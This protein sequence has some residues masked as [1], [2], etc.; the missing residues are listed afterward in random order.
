MNKRVRIWLMIAAALLLLGAMAFAG[1]M[2]ILGWDFSTITTIRYQSKLHNITEN[3]QNIS[4]ECDTANVIFLP[5][6]NQE[7]QVGCYEQKNATHTVT[8]NGDDLIIKIEDKRKWYEHIGIFIDRPIVALY[9]P[10]STYGALKINSDTGDVTI[11]KNFTFQSIDISKDTGDIT[12]LASA[13]DEVK[14]KTSTGDIS[15][16]SITAKSLDLTVSTGD[17]SVFDVKCQTLLS[18]GNTGDIS[19]QNVIAEGKFSIERSTGDV[20]FKKCDA[21]EIFVTTDT[22]DVTGS[23]Q[24]EKIFFAQSDTGRIDVPKTIHGGRCEIISDTGNIKINIE[25]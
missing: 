16:K 25:S 22:G 15:L 19:L 4:I 20:K 3:F 8:V 23:L 2:T 11:S 24:S 21:P 10:E 9:L 17:I 1:A 6:K 12:N 7:C 14:L 5:S 13:T 18:K